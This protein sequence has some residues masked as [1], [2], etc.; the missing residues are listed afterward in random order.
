MKIRE[1]ISHEFITNLI[2]RENL[3]HQFYIDNNDKFEQY[4]KITIKEF[5]F[6]RKAFAL[7][8][9]FKEEERMNKIS[10]LKNKI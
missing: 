3:V 6:N 5:I 10:Q 9:W 2:I 4:R 8:A 1:K 7:M